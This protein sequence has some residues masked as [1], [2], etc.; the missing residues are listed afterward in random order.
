MIIIAVAGISSSLLFFS[1]TKQNKE[2]SNPSIAYSDTPSVMGVSL[3]SIPTTSYDPAGA[4]FVSTSGS[5]SNSGTEASPYLTVL[6]A[7][8]MATSGRTIV[9]R[10]GTYRETLNTISKQV[11]L[12]PYPNEQVWISGSDVVSS[13]TSIGSGMVGR[14]NFAKLQPAM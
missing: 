8:Q 13:W 7:V 4:I 11:F 5:D 1:Q 10:E 12:Q 6:K 14:Q 3:T 9:I 2:I